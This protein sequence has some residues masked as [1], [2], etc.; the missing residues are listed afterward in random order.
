MIRLFQRISNVKE[1]IHFMVK[2]NTNVLDI[3]NNNKESI[4]DDDT[5][6]YHHFTPIDHHIT[7]LDVTPNNISVSKDPIPLDPPIKF[8]T[9]DDSFGTWVI[10]THHDGIPHAE[11]TTEP[12]HPTHEHTNDHVELENDIKIIETTPNSTN[13]I[14][15]A[16]DNATQ[17]I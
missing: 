3:L 5:P 7:S 11:N 16:P 15:H 2:K 1:H 9:F 13:T 17:A 10:P 4:L 12:N 8:P 6:L 14:D